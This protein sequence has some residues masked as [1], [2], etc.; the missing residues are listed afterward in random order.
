MSESAPGGAELLIVAG[1]ASGDLHAARLLAEV[2][3]R[4]PDLRAYGLG[5]QE[6]EAAGCR[7]LA[8]SAEI[9]VVGI[10]EVLRILPRAKEIF[11]QILE[12]VDALGTRTAVL[13]DF[14]EFNLRL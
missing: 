1:E 11:R 13:V 14:P 6:L 9:S 10:A 8:D 3:A 5:G 2:V 4:R 7:R 12:E